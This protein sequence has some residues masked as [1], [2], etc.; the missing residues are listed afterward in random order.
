MVCC[1]LYVNLFFFLF[2][3]IVERMTLGQEE[4]APAPEPFEWDPSQEDM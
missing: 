1:R 4:E 2:D 3:F